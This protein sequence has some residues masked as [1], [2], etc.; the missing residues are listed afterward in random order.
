M[1]YKSPHCRLLRIKGHY[2]QIYR[3]NT[4]QRYVSTFERFIRILNK[5]FSRIL[6]KFVYS[7]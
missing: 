7:L 5:H 4:L 2:L 3:I 1:L 6:M